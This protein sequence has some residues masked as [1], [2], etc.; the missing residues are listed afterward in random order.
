MGVLK[1]KHEQTRTG[2]FIHQPRRPRFGFDSLIFIIYYFYKFKRIFEFKTTAEA[3]TW[4]KGRPVI[5]QMGFDW[6]L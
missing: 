3:E 4:Q 5:K 6:Q 1:P 2:V